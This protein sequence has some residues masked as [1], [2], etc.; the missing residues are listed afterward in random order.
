MKSSQLQVGSTG[1]LQTASATNSQPLGSDGSAFSGVLTTVSTFTRYLT[2]N[3]P[4]VCLSQGSFPYANDP[5][6]PLP[7]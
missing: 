6:A 7:Q 2:T 1:T 4:R 3:A 5:G